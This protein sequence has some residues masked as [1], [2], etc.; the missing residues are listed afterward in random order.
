MPCAVRKEDY[1][2][3]INADLIRRLR[4]TDSSS[5]MTVIPLEPHTIP[6]PS[7]PPKTWAQFIN[8]I[9]FLIV[10]DFGS[11]MI[12]SSQF[13]FLAPL[14]LLPFPWARELYEEGIRYTKGAFGSLLG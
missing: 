10:F 11:L 5:A 12:N 2:T 14:L 1:V 8:A 4:V 3:A 6:I 9:S 13:V 7:R